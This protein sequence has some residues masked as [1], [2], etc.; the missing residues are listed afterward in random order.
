MK[1]QEEQGEENDN[2]NDLSGI[3]SSVA[4]Q[5]QKLLSTGPAAGGIGDQVR[6]WAKAQNQVQTKIQENLANV[7]NKGNAAKFLFGPDYKAIGELKMEMEQNRV[8]VQQLEQLKLKLQNQADIT[9]VQEMIALINE[10]NTALQERISLEEA[11]PSI[12]GWLMKLLVK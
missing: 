5:I 7:E 2:K 12:F 11:Q 9:N 3:R 1:T 10:E 8:R 6:E 4:Q